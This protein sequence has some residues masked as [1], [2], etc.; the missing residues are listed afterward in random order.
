MEHQITKT[1][2]NGA[3]TVKTVEVS[4]FSTTYVTSRM[5]NSGMISELKKNGQILQLHWLC[6][7]RN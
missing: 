4:F 7:C 6:L 5:K 1:V 2:W 3:T